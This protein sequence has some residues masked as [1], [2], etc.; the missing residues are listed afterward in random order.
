[1]IN[2]LESSKV[3]RMAELSYYKKHSTGQLFV[4]AATDNNNYY[5]V[6]TN[7]DIFSIHRNAMH[8]DILHWTQCVVI[9][10]KDF[11]IKLD[12]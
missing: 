6:Q 3:F 1:M 5:S 7:V 2:V 4:W 8:I 11:C 10:G 9:E 12:Y